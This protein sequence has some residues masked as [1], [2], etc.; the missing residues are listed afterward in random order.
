M[1]LD[2]TV[3]DP[4]VTRAVPLVEMP[5]VSVESRYRPESGSLANEILGCSAVP[6]GT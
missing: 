5:T 1:S 4:N 6:S 2:T 3:V